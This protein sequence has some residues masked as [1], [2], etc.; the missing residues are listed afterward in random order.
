MILVAFRHSDTRAFPRIV[1]FFRG[2]D[3]GH[4]EAALPL[5]GPL[6]MCV[7]AS[8]MDRGVRGKAIDITDPAKWRVYRVHDHADPLAWLA[9]NN[10]KKYDTLGLLVSTLPTVP[11]D[12]EKKVCSE[13]VAEMLAWLPD[14]PRTYDLV[15]LENAVKQRGE[16]VSWCNG[17]WVEI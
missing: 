11:D 1:R 8:F 7:S 4:V 17:Q 13:S 15:K 6:H 14:P 9:N 5:H 16:L 3:S 10:R 12:P 2:G